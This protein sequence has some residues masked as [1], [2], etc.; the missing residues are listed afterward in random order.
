MQWLDDRLD[1]AAKRMVRRLEASMREWLS[2]D[3]LVDRVARLISERICAVLT[4]QFTRHWFEGFLR[5]A[6]FASVRE[7][8]EKRP[9]KVEVTLSDKEVD[10]RLKMATDLLENAQTAALKLD[11][12]F[13]RSVGEVVKSISAANITG[14]VAERLE[15][16]TGYVQKLD[17]VSSA[18]ARRVARDLAEKVPRG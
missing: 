1:R 7:Y 17:D 16:L 18:L 2:A 9:P 11:A 12:S 10:R 3:D 15:P 6:A 5:E 13:A 8:F 14:I 4:E